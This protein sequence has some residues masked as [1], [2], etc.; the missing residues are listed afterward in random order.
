MEDHGSHGR[1]VPLTCRKGHPWGPAPLSVSWAPCQCSTAMEDPG[2]GHLVVHCSQPGCAE[3]WQTD[4]DTLLTALEDRTNDAAADRESTE[5]IA[6]LEAVWTLLMQA[7]EHE[8]GLLRASHPSAARIARLRSWI[9]DCVTA[10]DIALQSEALTARSDK[11]AHVTE[12]ATKVAAIVDAFHIYASMLER[13]RKSGQV[14]IGSPR[15]GPLAAVA[16]DERVL[17]SCR[18]DLRESMQQLIAAL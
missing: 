8:R 7:H 16:D 17:L 12:I 1:K 14:T 3:I 2:R 6:T 5:V 18:A 9:Q 13:S 11:V 10:I 15:P 4:A